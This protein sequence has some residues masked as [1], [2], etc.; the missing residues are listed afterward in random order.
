MW[1]VGKGDVLSPVRHG[2][3]GRVERCHERAVPSWPSHRTRAAVSPIGAK[4]AMTGMRGEGRGPPETG[5]RSTSVSNPAG[6][7]SDDWRNASGSAV[8][9]SSMNIADGGE[10]SSGP[11]IVCISPRSAITHTGVAGS[12]PSMSMTG[13]PPRAGRTSPS[14]ASLAS[15]RSIRLRCRA[16]RVL[17]KGVRPKLLVLRRGLSSVADV[18]PIGVDLDD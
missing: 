4:P 16:R 11:R 5:P 14:A 1:C 6:Q 17:E 3:G 12:C 10:R 2:T 8:W 9:A 7:L 15:M 13:A 18:R